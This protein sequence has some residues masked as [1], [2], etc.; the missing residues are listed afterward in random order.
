[1]D[2]VV[3]AV[4]GLREFRDA[5]AKAYQGADGAWDKI[6]DRPSMVFVAPEYMFAKA[7]DQFTHDRLRLPD[8]KTNIEKALKE[9]SADLGTSA[10]LAPGSISYVEPLV[11]NPAKKAEIEQRLK[12]GIGATKLAIAAATAQADADGAYWRKE[13]NN[14]PIRIPGFLDNAIKAQT[15][16]ARLRTIKPQQSSVAPQTPTANQ[17]QALLNSGDVKFVAKNE[18]VLYHKGKDVARYAKIADY[19]E[20]PLTRYAA[21]L[22]CTIFIPGLKP[23]RATVGGIPWGVEVCFDHNLGVLSVAKTEALP[24]VHLLCSAAVDRE[25]KHSVVKPGGY[26]IHSS[27]NSK[28]CGIWRKDLQNNTYAKIQ[29]SDKLSVMGGE[30]TLYEYV[31]ELNLS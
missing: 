27:S 7:G 9:L 10:V 25:E 15:R 14:F 19:G 17:K 13:Y 23:G 24:M 8:E 31:I 30:G 29:K 26:V 6:H 28:Q 5:Q 18:M 12:M 20:V 11:L 1:M 3:E 2:L 22:D 4:Y 21:G 16:A